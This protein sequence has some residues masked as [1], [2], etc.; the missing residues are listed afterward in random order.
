[1][2][3]KTQ[4][5]KFKIIWPQF[6]LRIFLLLLLVIFSLA[7]YFIFKIKAFE[8]NINDSENQNSSIIYTTQQFVKKEKQPLQGEERKRINILLLGM[9]GEGHHGQYLTDTILLASINPQTYETA[10]LA[11]P[12]DLYVKIP[13]TQIHTK[14]NAVYAYGKNNSGDLGNKPHGLIKKTVEEITGQ[15]IDYH[16]AINFEGFKKVIDELGGIIIQVEE[17]I[18]DHK[19]PGPGRSY[20]TFK[21]D[22]GTHLVNGDVALK[23][24]RVRHVKG[25]D[26]SRLERQKDIILSAKKRAFSLENFLNPIRISNLM[27]I[28]EENLQTDIQLDEIPAFIELLNK[29]NPYN[30]NSKVLDAWSP[31]SLLAVSHVLLGNVQAFILVPRTGNYQ[32]IQDLTENIFDLNKIEKEK[33]AIEKESARILVVSD[34]YQNSPR[35]KNFFEKMGY[36]V[37]TKEDS[38]IY[39]NCQQNIKIF[40]PQN[41][42][43]I[44]TLNDLTRKFHA[45]IEESL[46]FNYSEQEM[47]IVLCFP[48]K[49]I[50]KIE[51]QIDQNSADDFQEESILD[52]EGNIMYNEN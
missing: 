17:D 25:G 42:E 14:I 49:E 9:G 27:N 12:R 51:K 44:Y 37:E 43:K 3:K 46:N 23:Y 24:A 11:I 2:F 13:E 22:K 16:I 8:K 41:S 4:K 6:L 15:K 19:Y 35:V 45:E 52:N 5:P 30:I 34:Q 36:S 29:I 33:E 40:A 31:D 1:V 26:F 39:Q 38:E 47:D 7:G 10:L 18:V 20:E 32:E 50:E 21:I 48:K 28:L